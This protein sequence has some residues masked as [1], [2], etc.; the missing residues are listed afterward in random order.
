MNIGVVIFLSSQSSP[1]IYSWCDAAALFLALPV[2]SYPPDVVA[3]RSV[4]QVSHNDLL[5]CDVI[6]CYHCIRCPSWCDGSLLGLTFSL[7]I[8][9]LAARILTYNFRVVVFS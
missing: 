6:Q 7:G 1:S 9:Y 4:S 8:V 5:F 2:F 3:L